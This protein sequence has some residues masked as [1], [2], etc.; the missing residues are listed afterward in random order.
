MSLFRD[1][2][3][4]NNFSI[5]TIDVS[6]IDRA[7][8]F[9]PKN[10]VID[11]N[12]AERA[13]SVTLEG[14]NLCQEKIAQIDRWIGVKE[15][16]KNRAWS[17]A[18]LVKA[19]AAQIKTVKEK[20]WFAQSDS[21]YINACNNLTLAKAC[22]KWFENKANYFQTWHYAIKTFL[23]RDYSIENIG[24]NPIAAYNISYPDGLPPGGNDA[25][26]EW[27]EVSWK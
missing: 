5:E 23:R 19:K 25:D 1:R 15:M 13:L 2:V 11:L 18:A 21:D 20:E 4:I 7:S 16:E 10:G 12:I 24:S 14:Q 17:A 9:L 8:D 22:K 6:E 27:G 3:N 26:E